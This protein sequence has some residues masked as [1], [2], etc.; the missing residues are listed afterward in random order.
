MEVCPANF[1]SV[2]TQYLKTFGALIMVVDAFSRIKLPSERVVLNY[3]NVERKK[4]RV[5]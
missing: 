1:N 5:R 3:D 4:L 2:L